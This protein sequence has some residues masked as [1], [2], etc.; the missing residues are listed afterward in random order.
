MFVVKIPRQHLSPRG[1]TGVKMYFDAELVEPG[2]E[3]G[4]RI[5]GFRLVERNG[6]SFLGFPSSVGKD[7]KRY[8]SFI[9]TKELSEAIQVAA[10]MVYGQIA[11]K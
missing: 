11:K 7:G 3:K 9:P 1:E 6:K 8:P 10:E 5:N 4:H 2:A